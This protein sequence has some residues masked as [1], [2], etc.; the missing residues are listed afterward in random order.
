M[1]PL[2]SE[3]INRLQKRGTVEAN[4]RTADV[5]RDEPGDDRKNSLAAN[6]DT[7]TQLV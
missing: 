3:K 1:T 4:M 6:R 5:L 7:A 2:N